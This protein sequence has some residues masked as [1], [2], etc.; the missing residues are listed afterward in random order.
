MGLLRSQETSDLLSARWQSLPES[1]KLPNQVVGRFWVQC[2][3][4]LGSSY[5]SFGCSHCYLPANANRVPLVSLEEMKAQIDANRRV[6]GKG[7][8]I[9]VTGGDL[10]D[11]YVKANKTDELIELIR[12]CVEQDLIPMLMTHGQGL[13]DNRGLLEALVQQGGLRKLS[14]HIDT[15]QAGRPG[16]PKKSI[17]YEHQLNPL[18]D[19]LVDLV[20]S[21][22]KNTGKRLV[23]STNR[24]GH[25]S[26][27][28]RHQRYPGLVGPSAGKYGSHQDNE[29]S[30]RSGSW[31]N[32]ESTN[33]SNG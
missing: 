13:L 2:G 8:H 32:P 11:A 19:Q 15:T 10:V 7:G 27:P 29:F 9:Q 5:C 31:P 6:L 23:C 16:F 12:Y 22:R 33:S 3:F 28:A 18:R 26:K 30:N 17:Q 20:L 1:L 14:C 24:H 25:Q 21:V 4:T